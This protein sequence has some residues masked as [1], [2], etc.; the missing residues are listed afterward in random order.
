MEKIKV[1]ILTF[2]DGRRHIHEDLK[3]TNQRYQMQLATDL[4][5]TGEVEVVQGREIINTSRIAQTEA[6]RLNQEGVEMTIFNYAIW[7]FPHLSA[8]AANFAPG[9]FLLFCNLHPSEP[10]MVGM[11]AAAGTMDQLDHPY[12]RLWGSISEK[13]VLEKVLSYLRAVSAV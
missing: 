7:C 10:G 2:S 6:K 13:N 1:G 9:P 12:H 8:M 3:E 4:E 11:L 5:A